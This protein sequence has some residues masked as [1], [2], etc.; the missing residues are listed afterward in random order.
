MKGK[1]AKKETKK[2]STKG[3]KNAKPAAPAKGSKA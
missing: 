1:N 3:G 2:P